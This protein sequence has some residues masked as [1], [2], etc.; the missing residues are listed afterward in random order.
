MKI[1]I[2]NLKVLNLMGRMYIATMHILLTPYWVANRDQGAH[3]VITTP[4]A[5]PVVV[6]S[7]PGYPVVH[8][9]A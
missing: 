7:G 9:P 4:Q 5:T 6:M 8:P 2:E 3:I 1:K